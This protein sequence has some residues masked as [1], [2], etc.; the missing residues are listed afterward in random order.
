MRISEKRLKE[1]VGRINR[2]ILFDGA[3]DLIGVQGRYGY[4][5][6]DHYRIT[7]DGRLSCQCNIHSGTNKEC[8]QS[9]YD[10]TNTDRVTTREQAKAVLVLVGVDFTTQD[11]HELSMHIVDHLVT[12]AKLTKYRKPKNVVSLAFYF[13][14]HLSKNKYKH[15]D[16]DSLTGAYLLNLDEKW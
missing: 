11:F 1:T 5:A 3:I 6:I 14:Q 12:L 4:Q 7:P 10:F 2:R 9:A 8:L 16:I 13:Y 15:I